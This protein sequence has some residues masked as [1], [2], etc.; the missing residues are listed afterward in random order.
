MYNFRKVPFVAAGKTEHTA[1]PTRAYSYIKISHT[2][3][4]VIVLHA[5]EVNRVT[6]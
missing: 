4:N 3:L 1:M 6:K 2:E 5:V